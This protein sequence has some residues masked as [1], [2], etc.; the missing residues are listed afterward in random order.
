MKYSPLPLLFFACIYSVYAQDGVSIGRLAPDPSAILHVDAPEDDKGMLIPRLTTVERNNIITN[1]T[2]ATGLIIYNTDQQAFNYYDGSDWVRLIPTPAKFDINM[3]NPGSGTHHKITN[4]GNGTASRDAVN[5]GQLDTSISNVDAANLNRSG[6]EAMTGNLNVGS[7]RITNLSDGVNDTDAATKGQLDTEIGNIELP[8]LF[9]STGG[10]STFSGGTR[11]TVID[12]GNTD[13]KQVD[14]TAWSDVVGG[15]VRIRLS[16]GA[17]STAN[18][19]LIQR[20]F[21]PS[22]GAPVVSQE[23]VEFGV[24]NTTDRYFRIRVIPENGATVGY[25]GLKVRVRKL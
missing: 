21:Q 10:S 3:L 11:S 22:V 4:L 24:F 20:N 7:N 8:E 2:P 25:Y 23:S 6:N 19:L 13:N 12:T 9:T 1:V 18:D 16:S 5:K 17:T 14:I 15:L